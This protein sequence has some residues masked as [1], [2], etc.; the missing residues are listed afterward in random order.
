MRRPDNPYFARAAVNRFWLELTGR[1][2]VPVADGFSPIA[3]V[4]H[5]ALLDQLAAG[6]VAHDYD[7]KWLMRTIVCSQVFQLSSGDDSRLGEEHW[8][9]AAVLPLNGD[10]W[11]D[12]V[13]RTSGAEAKLLELAAEL[14]PLLQEGRNRRLAERRDLLL[15]AEHNLR[16]H[17]Y[18]MRAERVPDPEDIPTVMPVSFEGIDREAL[19]KLSKRY[20]AAGR[21]LRETRTQARLSL[22]P[23]GTSLLRMNGKLISESLHDGD[24]KTE[25]ANLP[26]GSARLH[27][28]YLHVLN[29]TPTLAERQALEPLLEE[30]NADRVTD[31]MW[32]LMQS[33]EFQTR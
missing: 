22:G 9:V 30:E 5:E 16:Q 33:T 11:H 19:T 18:V 10:Q 12:S 14:D 1:G 8:E 6:F 28:A 31:L 2:F 15:T 24:T 23:T 25:I 3:T 27:S 29:R 32:A 4:A 20:Q 17:G 13:L 7:L 21:E 26:T